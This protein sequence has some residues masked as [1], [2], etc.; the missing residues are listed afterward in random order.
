MTDAH[1]P[2]ELG[3]LSPA[4]M[5]RWIGLPSPGSKVGSQW[6]TD[7]PVTVESPANTDR[8][9]QEHIT[10]KVLNWNGLVHSGPYSGSNSPPSN[11][12]EWSLGPTEPNS[13]SRSQDRGAQFPPGTT[14]RHVGLVESEFAPNRPKTLN[15]KP[16]NREMTQS[17]IKQ[18]RYAAGLSP[19]LQPSAIDIDAFISEGQKIM[20]GR[21]GHYPYYFDN[22]NR[23]LPWP[24][25]PPSE[26]GH[27]PSDSA[28]DSSPPISVSMGRSDSATLG[29]VEYSS[30][31]NI[32]QPQEQPP[33]ERNYSPDPST[34]N[35]FP[36]FSGIH[37]NSDERIR[38][39]ENR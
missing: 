22:P 20:Y 17:F 10:T 26:G 11:P 3:L 27:R 16:G 14:K 2:R 18:H 8:R 15:R 25:H 32:R 4:D 19:S 31:P 9:V 34:V 21:R 38:E 12:T 39:L 28:L 30:P 1:L 6:S 7:E 36:T 23:I 5:Y 37:A 13:P 35:V 33:I 24:Q 29:R